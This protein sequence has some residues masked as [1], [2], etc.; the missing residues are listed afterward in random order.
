MKKILFIT[1]FLYSYIGI[2]YADELPNMITYCGIE[3]AVC[4]DS[5]GKAG[6]NA[7]SGCYWYDLG[8][9]CAKVSPSYYKKN[10]GSQTRCSG[11]SYSW[12][13]DDIYAGM[14]DNLCPWKTTCQ[15]SQYWNPGSMS[16]EACTSR[17]GYVA[18][19][20]NATKLIYGCGG[21]K[22]PASDFD[23]R[24]EA[25]AYV[26]KLHPG[27][28]GFTDPINL[29]VKQGT[30][31]GFSSSENGPWTS[32][33][34]LDATLPGPNLE[35]WNKPDSN[36]KE[37]GFLGYT[38][39][40]TEKYIT[41]TGNLAPGTYINNFEPNM[42]LTGA[43]QD[44]YYNVAYVNERGEQ[45]YIDEKRNMASTETVRTGISDFVVD[46][47][48]FSH[49]TCIEG[50]EESEIQLGTLLPKP[51]EDNGNGYNYIYT[52]GNSPK[53]T[54]KLGPVYTSCPAGYYCVNNEKNPCPGGTTT[55]TTSTTTN[56]SITNCFMSGNVTYLK[57]NFTGDNKKVI[58]DFIPDA[59]N[60]KMYY[61]Q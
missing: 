49:W 60:V 35:W 56:S 53:A 9:T 26:V 27:R 2:I 31:G 51:A 6:C 46:G 11:P 41:G 44:V 29:Y 48:I 14:T 19:A 20:G 34:G 25:V 42:E 43:W 33:P 59:I 40:P 1:T 30:S 23:A 17:T 47:K 37:Y 8:N 5:Y 3:S 45:I 55:I 12:L 36:G 39:G 58:R 4:E 54:M 52:E 32:Q 24:C 18:R 10:G 13:T 7:T 15:P 16:C 57:D 21:K 50:C 61:K 22:Y 38:Q 28:E